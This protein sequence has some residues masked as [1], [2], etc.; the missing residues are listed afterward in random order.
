[1]SWKDEGVDQISWLI[2]EI[3]TNPQSRRLIVSLW[4]P[5]DLP[6]MR[7]PPCH[8]AWHIEI[9]NEGR[10]SLLLNQRSTDTPVGAIV[11]ICFYSALCYMLSQQTGYKPYEFIHHMENAHIYEN[12]IDAVKEYLSRPEVDSPKLKLNKA[13]DIFSYS[14]ADF[15]L[16]NYNP[17]S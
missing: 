4:N 11:N 2:N 1:S 15:E 13:K 7:L 14:I 3:K 16:I 10:M 6:L 9:D 12:Q 5:K 17:L 8:Y